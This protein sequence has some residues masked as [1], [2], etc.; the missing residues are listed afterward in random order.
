M[1][2]KSAL[3]NGP[4][5][6]RSMWSNHQA[7]KMKNILI[8]CINSIRHSMGLSKLQEN[9]MNDLGIFSVKTVLKLVKPILLF[10]RKVVKD[11]FV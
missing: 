7:W 8:I 2:V 1:D 6:K 4:I 10:T 3:L 9:G 5:M 11:L